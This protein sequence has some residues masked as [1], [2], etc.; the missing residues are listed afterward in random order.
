MM[1]HAG[2]V[3]EGG[4]TQYLFKEMNV[5]RILCFKNTPQ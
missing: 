4:R 5:V 1:I 2:G 3:G